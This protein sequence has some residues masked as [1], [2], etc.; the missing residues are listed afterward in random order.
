VEFDLTASPGEISLLPGPPTR[1]SRYTATLSHGPASTLQPGDESFLGPVI[2][3]RRGQRVRVRFKNQ[4][5]EP[6]IVHWHGL[7]LPELA[8]G[9]PRLA[10]EAGGEYLYEFRVTNRAGTYWNHPHPHMRTGAQVYQGLAGV[11]LVTDPEE[12]ALALPT[13]AGEVLCVLQDRRFDAANQF[14]YAPSVAGR[15]MGR[16]GM[17]GRMGMGMGGTMDAAKGWLG[18][19]VLINGRAQTTVEADRRTYR[20]RVLNG[21]NA[22][23][24]KLAWSDASPLVIIGGDGGLLQRPRTQRT[25]TLAPGQRAD[26]IRDLSD[27]TPGSVINLVSLPFPAEDVAAMMTAGTPSVPQGTALRLMSLRVSDRQGPRWEVPAQLSTDD[28]QPMSA[29]PVRHVTLAF[30]Q[31]NWFLDGRVFELLDAAD[32]ETVAAG[33]THIWELA[34]QDGMMGMTMAH[35]IHLHGAQYRVLSRTGGAPNALRE[36]IVDEGWKDTVVVLPGETVRI[37]ITFST[38][39]GLYLYHCHILEHEDMGMMRNFRIRA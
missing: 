9:H 2:R 14:V 35:P 6:S 33:S 25:L 15:G 22:R 28:F 32:E 4:L 13:G 16:G 39:P 36:G 27:H 26:L 34:N 5:D 24:Y 19:R 37:Q 20:L 38:Q 7:D 1:V 30:R 10:I 17:G 3:L 18:D 31:M 21:S 11:V 23:F 12:D 8:D 29:A